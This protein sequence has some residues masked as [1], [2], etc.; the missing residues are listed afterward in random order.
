MKQWY[1]AHNVMYIKFKDGIQDKYPFWENII[2]IHAESMDDAIAAAK[3]RAKTDEGDY[4]G[5]FT[6][7]GRPATWV[8]AGVRQVVLCVDPDMPPTHGTELTFL[9][10][11]VPTKDDLDKFMRGEDTWILFGD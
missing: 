1:V 9:N 11:E 2:L 4:G 10:L 5:T 3:I 6:S 8:F 7:E